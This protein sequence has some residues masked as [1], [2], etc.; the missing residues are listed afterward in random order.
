MRTFTNA[1]VT[2]KALKDFLLD[3]NQL[4]NSKLEDK[5]IEGD[6]VTQLVKVS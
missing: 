2:G 4:N 1:V 6:T 3:I 5:L